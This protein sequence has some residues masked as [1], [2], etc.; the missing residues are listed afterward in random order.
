MLYGHVGIEKRR[1]PME[2]WMML[3]L[4]SAFASTMFAISIF[5]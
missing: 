5:F 2:S 1:N 3:T 4:L